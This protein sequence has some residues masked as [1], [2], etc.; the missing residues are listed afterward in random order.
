MIRQAGLLLVRGLV[1]ATLSAPIA[2]AAQ[3]VATP[4]PQAA[5]SGNTVGTVL[6]ISG[7]VIPGA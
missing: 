1:A 2:V 5:P 4:S 3:T 7:A 6:D